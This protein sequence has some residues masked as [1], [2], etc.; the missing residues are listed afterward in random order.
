MGRLK[1]LAP[2]LTRPPPRIGFLAPKTEAEAS[3]DRDARLAYRQWY[4]TARWQRL[5]WSVLVR[6]HFTCRR[7]FRLEGNTAL[8]V[9]DHIVPHR[10]DHAL[11]WDDDNLQ[12]LCKPCHDSAKQRE[13]A[14]MGR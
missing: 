11:F 9:A 6:D 2:V 12:T 10:G 14:R 13:E 5:R 8:L 3:R 1:Q 7:C 4:K